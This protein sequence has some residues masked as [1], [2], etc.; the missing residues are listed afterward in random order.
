MSGA[1][2]DEVDLVTKVWTIPKSRMNG[3]REHRARVSV[4]AIVVIERM[5]NRRE[6]NFV[7]PD[8]S[9]DHLSNM[10]LLMLLRR[11]GRDDLTAHGLRAT[12]KVLGKRTDTIPAK[13]H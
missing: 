6:N 9:R 4:A 11:M 12:F 8:Y 3:G 5:Q 1:T 13:D 10:A 7:F 2:W